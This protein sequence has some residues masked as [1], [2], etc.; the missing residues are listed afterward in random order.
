ME[1]KYQSDDLTELPLGLAG[2]VFRSPM[3]Y[4]LYDHDEDL[5]ERYRQNGVSTVVLLVEDDEYLDRTGR[6]LKNIYKV[7]GMEVL[8][9][10]VPDFGVPTLDS[11]KSGV[12]KTLLHVSKGH[13]TVI[14]CYAGIGRTGTFA[15]CLAKRVLGLSGDEAI[16]W[17][18]KYIPGAV[19]VPSQI[20]LVKD[21]E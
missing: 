10:P 17:V 12:E 9:L 15:A 6:D 19:E 4:S 18:R 20:K 1:N 13:N 2:R 5:V 21:F 3:P 7:M 11:L 14:H 8:H 16:G